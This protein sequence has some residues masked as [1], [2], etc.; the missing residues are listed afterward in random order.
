MTKTARKSIKGAPKPRKPVD[1]SVK[2]DYQNTV[3]LVG[4]CSG[5]GLE[6]KLPSGDKV[7]ELRVVV[8]R[9]DRDGYDTFDVALWSSVLRK[10][11]LSLK[12]EEWVEVDGVLRRRFW[13]MGAGAVSR[14]Q[15]EGRQLRRV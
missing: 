1:E 2:D 12:E 5:V 7:V 6:K 11:G 8:K 4:R 10:R 13:K 15:V 14:W 3:R 9:H